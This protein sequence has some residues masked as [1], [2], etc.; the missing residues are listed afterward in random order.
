MVS[1]KKAKEILFHVDK[2]FPEYKMGIRKSYKKKGNHESFS[3][4]TASNSWI[5]LHNFGGKSKSNGATESILDIETEY[6][7]KWVEK[8]I[9]RKLSYKRAVK[10]A[11]YG[12][13]RSDLKKLL[14]EKPEYAK[15]YYER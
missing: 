4:D 13:N 14:K 15:Y 11:L 7:G 10:Q 2:K 12:L 3:V 5:T 8:D 9:H 6:Y 1:F